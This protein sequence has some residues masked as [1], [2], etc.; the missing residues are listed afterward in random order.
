M[1]VG[2]CLVVS[3]ACNAREHGV[4]ARVSV[5]IG[6]GRP[7]SRMSAGIDGELI[8]GKCG[9]CPRGRRMARCARR[10]ERS[11]KM[12]RIRDTGVVGLVARVTIG[13]CSGVTASHVTVRASDLCVRAGQRENG[14]RMIEGRRYPCA[15]VVAD[16]AGLWESGSDVIRVRC[17]I[18]IRQMARIAKSAE[19]CVLPARVTV[20]TSGIHVSAG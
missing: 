12:V 8:V 19:S 1:L 14:L 4:V 9:T 17:V 16:F 10:W 3:V 13:R 2:S 7:F 11:R 18:E 5:A 20:R 6:A 15:C